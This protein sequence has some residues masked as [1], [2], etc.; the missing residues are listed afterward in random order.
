MVCFITFMVV[1][2]P[3]RN[4]EAHVQIPVKT[5]S[6]LLPLAVISILTNCFLPS[7]K[8]MYVLYT[9]PKVINHPKVQE[10]IQAIPDITAD[11]MKLTQMWLKD[12][13]NAPIPEEPK[14]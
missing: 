1:N 2:E 8:E 11:T 3:S 6:I 7:T 4:Y 14:K 10:T 5:L 13:L 12:K 9:I